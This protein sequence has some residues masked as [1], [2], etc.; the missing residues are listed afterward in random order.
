MKFL[1]YLPLLLCLLA[2][3][4]ACEKEI[5]YDFKEHPTKLVMN[6][7]INADKET[8][9][10]YLNFTGKERSSS[11]QNARL[12]VRVNGVL[13]EELQPVYSGSEPVYP[14]QFKISTRFA[15]GDVV[16]MDAFAEEGL[17]HAWAEVEVPQRPA[18]IRQVEHSWT[19]LVQNGY[20]REYMRYRISI[21]DRPGEQNFY[22]L[23][24]D[25]QTEVELWEPGEDGK[26]QRQ[27][28]HI[29]EFIGREDV[30]LTDGQPMNGDDEDNGL[31]DTVKNMYAVFD[32][33]RFQDTSYTMTVYN[34]PEINTYSY[35]KF[36][37]MDVV[38][39]LESLSETAYY[40]LKALNTIES[41]GYD[42]AINEPISFPSNVHGG[43]GIVSISTGNTY[44][45]NIPVE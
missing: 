2:L 9:M 22:R 32:D 38:F 17:Y 27:V 10:L 39:R 30:V 25:Q 23:V 3:T 4:T 21:E 29:Y 16:R 26:P 42:E 41:D 36:I 45:V 43:T 13:K 12:E 7:L 31:F 1:R 34:R 20:S 37:R 40:Y 35:E 33:S 19:P 15:P 5:P 18:P 11:T 6:A 44:T 8:N 14:C 24:V 28:R